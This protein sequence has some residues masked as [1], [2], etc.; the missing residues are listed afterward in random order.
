MRQ[1]REVRLGF[2]AF[3]MAR[4]MLSLWVGYIAAAVIS[5]LLGVVYFTV[6]NDASA[7]AGPVLGLAIFGWAQHRFPLS[8]GHP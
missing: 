7:T 3:W 5:A 6:S 8:A 1:R 4:L 2:A